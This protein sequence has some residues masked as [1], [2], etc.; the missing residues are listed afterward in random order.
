MSQEFKHSRRKTMSQKKIKS[1]D[2]KQRQENSNSATS[3]FTLL[4]ETVLSLAAYQSQLS[5]TYLYQ[6]GNN[7][8]VIIAHTHTPCRLSLHTVG[9]TWTEVTLA[10]NVPLYICLLRPTQAALVELV[11]GRMAGEVAVGCVH[12]C[13]RSNVFQVLGIH[14]TEV[15][16]SF[17]FLCVVVP[18]LRLAQAPHAV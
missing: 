14:P 3:G 4:Q 17:L 2:K 9:D 5:N 6:P 11:N 1:S 13:G 16:G 18:Y 7:C 15:A 12:T 10:G 8:W